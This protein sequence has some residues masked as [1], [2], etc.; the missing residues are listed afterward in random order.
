MGQIIN[1]RLEPLQV[2]MGAQFIPISIEVS[3]GVSLAEVRAEIDADN[4]TDLD[5]LD[6][7]DLAVYFRSR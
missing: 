1:N 2:Q 5:N 3:G 6:V 7:G 4:I